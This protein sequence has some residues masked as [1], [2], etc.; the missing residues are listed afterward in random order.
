M[1]RIHEIVDVLVF[2]AYILLGGYLTGVLL[3]QIPADESLPSYLGTLGM[4]LV[5]IL[6]VMMVGA[7]PQANLHEELLKAS[8]KLDT[9]HFVFMAIPIIVA[10]LVWWDAMF[11]FDIIWPAFWLAVVIGAIS[12]YII[13]EPRAQLEFEGRKAFAWLVIFLAA[14][15]LILW[16][17]FSA[18]LTPLQLATGFVV[19]GFYPFIVW[20][21][22]R[23]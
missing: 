1:G 14:A 10:A 4:V 22:A 19:G 21:M 12:Q 2:S 17:W 5:L 18:I 7:L 6:I 9:T 11:I 16:F 8:P 20:L 23:V 13:R 15:F 3:G